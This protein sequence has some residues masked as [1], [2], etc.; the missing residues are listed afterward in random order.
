MAALVV[1]YLSI[2]FHGADWRPFCPIRPLA[3]HDRTLLGWRHRLGYLWH[4]LVFRFLR[5]AENQIGTTTCQQKNRK[6]R[7]IKL[8]HSIPFQWDK[9]LKKE[10]WC[11]VHPSDSPLVSKDAYIPADSSSLERPLVREDSP[12][13]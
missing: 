5:W 3:S 12:Q 10:S 1:R 8:V 9:K 11:R 7:G 4:S 2:S 6:K 13:K